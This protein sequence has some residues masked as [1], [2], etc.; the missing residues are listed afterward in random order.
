MIFVEI[1]Q[2]LFSD[3]SVLNKVLLFNVAVSFA[4]R[5]KLL[6]NLCHIKC[7]LRFQNS[8]EAPVQLSSF[9]PVEEVI[10]VTA[11]CVTAAPP[12]EDHP[13]VIGKSEAKIPCQDYLPTCERRVGKFPNQTRR[14][15]HLQLYI[16][17]SKFLSITKFNNLLRR[18]SSQKNLPSFRGLFSCHYNELTGQMAV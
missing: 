11:L 14:H 15:G 18:S 9:S 8:F 13:G 7:H 2:L 1:L 6:R 5:L 10:Y 3:E 4:Q 12:A 16:T 17:K